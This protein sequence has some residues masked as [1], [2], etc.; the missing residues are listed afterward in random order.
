M[1]PS[2]PA[3]LESVEKPSEL[4]FKLIIVGD[5][6]AG[7]TSVIHRYCKGSFTD[8]YKVTIGVDFSSKTITSG[9]KTAVLNLFDIAGHERFGSML[10][11]YY[12][13]SAGAVVVFDV[14]RESTFD[15]VRRWANDID[16]K[17]HLADE[18]PIPKILL[19]NKVDLIGNPENELD[20]E[21]LDALCEELGFSKWFATSAKTGEGLGKLHHHNISTREVN[22]RNKSIEREMLLLLM[23]GGGFFWVFFPFSYLRPPF[24]CSCILLSPLLNHISN[25][26]FFL[27]LDN[28]RGGIFL[29][30]GRSICSSRQDCVVTTPIGWNWL[31]YH[32]NTRGERSEETREEGEKENWGWMLLKREVHVLCLVR[33]LSSQEFIGMESDERKKQRR[34]DN[35]RK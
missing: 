9:D 23:Y 35:G 33:I 8:N 21:R 26:S 15:T 20:K 14:T 28:C 19:A 10:R 2:S 29:L 1:N 22:I 17:V 31:G 4:V 5:Y 18:T 11:L 24:V 25:F 16:E 27:C 6:A 7:K 12:R 30:G 3:E 34:D 13:H 32:W